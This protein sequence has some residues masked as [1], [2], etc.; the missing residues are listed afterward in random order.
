M[1]REDDVV[2]LAMYDSP[3]DAN[4][5]KGVLETNGVIA[6][7]MGDSTANAL[8]QGFRQGAIRVVVLR[9]DL[10]KAREIL[11]S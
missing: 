9:K 7:V 1:E 8:M 5:I 10:Q 3:V 6:G 2:V 4:I 11:D